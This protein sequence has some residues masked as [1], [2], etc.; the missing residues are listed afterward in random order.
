MC[1]RGSKPPISMVGHG[2]EPD[3][4]GLYIHY[5]D[6]L[7]SRRMT[8]PQYKELIIPA[9]SWHVFDRQ[10]LR[11]PMH[12]YVVLMP[13]NGDGPFKKW[14]NHNLNRCLACS[15]KYKSKKKLLETKPYLSKI[16]ERNRC[17]F[18]NSL[19]EICVFTEVNIMFFVLV[20]TGCLLLHGNLPGVYPPPMPRFP[21]K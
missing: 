21:K 16:S 9:I 17:V 5:T 15:V 8:I 14:W 18:T 19:G 20:K 2:H 13:K 7:V 12:N 11:Y 1:E 4:M 10:H 3:S 6:S